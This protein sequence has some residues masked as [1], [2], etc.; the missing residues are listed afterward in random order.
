MICRSAI[1]ALSVAVLAPLAACSADSTS[2]ADTPRPI[3][4]AALGA[5]LRVTLTARQ[6]TPGG[7]QVDFSAAVADDDGAGPGYTVDYGDGKTATVPAPAASCSPQRNAAT[8]IATT[9]VLHHRYANPGT[10]AVS[11]EVTSGTSCE[12]PAPETQTALAL[13]NVSR[14]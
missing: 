8:P 4:S 10:Y 11:I 13:V 3:S 9:I 1:T 2:A 12:L 6:A 14:G 5:G 7:A